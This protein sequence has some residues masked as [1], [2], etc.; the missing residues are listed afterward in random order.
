MQ[1]PTKIHSQQ[2]LFVVYNN[3]KH[4]YKEVLHK[5]AAAMNLVKAENQN[6]EINVAVI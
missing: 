3:I 5:R 1:N 6:K 4:T 2:S